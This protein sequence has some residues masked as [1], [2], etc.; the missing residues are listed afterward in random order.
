MFSTSA[1][2]KKNT[3]SEPKKKQQK[4][5]EEGC[6]QRINQNLTTHIILKIDIILKR[7]KY[8]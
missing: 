4:M 1:E 3:K 8:E 6:L 7:E 5:F 2:R